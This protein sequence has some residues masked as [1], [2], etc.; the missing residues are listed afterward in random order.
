MIREEIDWFLEKCCEVNKIP[1][2]VL[3]RKPTADGKLALERFIKRYEKLIEENNN[4]FFNNKDMARK[5]KI[6][7]VWQASFGYDTYVNKLCGVFDDEEKALELKA[8]LDTN[9][10]SAEDCWT[11]MPEDVWYGWPAVELDDSDYDFEYVVEYEGYTREQR[12]LQED[13]WVLMSEEYSPAVIEEAYMNE[14]R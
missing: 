6:Y 14:E 4:N 13:R 8:R 1:K 9:V 7:L 2:S 10:V 5:K 11:I 3:D 12:Q